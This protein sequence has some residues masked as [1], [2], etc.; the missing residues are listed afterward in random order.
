MS[1]AKLE[2]D[3]LAEISPNIANRYAEQPSTD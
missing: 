2:N 1:V 3:G